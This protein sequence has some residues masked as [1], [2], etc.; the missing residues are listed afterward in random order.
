M[1]CQSTKSSRQ[2]R[3]MVTEPNLT[4]VLVD[5]DV[6]SVLSSSCSLSPLLITSCLYTFTPG[7]SPGID[8]LGKT[9]GRDIY[10][11]IWHIYTCIW[12]KGE[13]GRHWGQF[14]FFTIFFW[15]RCSSAPPLC[16]AWRQ[17]CVTGR[18]KGNTPKTKPG[19]SLSKAD[20]MTF[21]LSSLVSI[22]L[23]KSAFCP[24]IC[25]LCYKLS[26]WFCKL[27]VQ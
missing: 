24:I 15:A 27:C 7:L 6:K 18:F 11:C 5:F 8:L 14:S 1:V 10:S 16:S 21:P 3:R 4:R 23:G 2:R 26:C 13:I 17:P 12:H 22:K 19:H 20:C 9:L 25:R